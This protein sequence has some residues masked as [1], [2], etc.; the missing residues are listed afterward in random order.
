MEE[1]AAT[2]EE[3]SIPT[4]YMHP[5][6]K[7][8]IAGDGR[9]L[10]AAKS[11]KISLSPEP[12][13]PP[14][15]CEFN[16]VAYNFCYQLPPEPKI[17]GRKFNCSYAQ[18]LDKLG[19]LSKLVRLDISIKYFQIANIRKLWPQRKIIIYNLGLRSKAIKEL[20]EKCLV[21]LRDFPFSTYP[22]YVKDLDQYRWK[23][24]TIAVRSFHLLLFQRYG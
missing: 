10:P 11:R 2:M 19:R 24:L 6:Y 8:Q 5:I 23:P 22:P 17:H 4:K 9:Q 15:Q 3:D 21:E 13:E 14:C 18:H 1:E 12:A 20:E 7:S 16:G